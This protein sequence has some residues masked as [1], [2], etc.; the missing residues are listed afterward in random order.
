MLGVYVDSSKAFDLINY[1]ILLKRLE[2]CR[3]CQT[4]LK[5][6]ESY[7]LFSTQFVSI[8]QSNSSTSKTGTEV[9]EGSV[10]K[11]LL[12]IQFINFIEQCAPEVKFVS[13]A[14]CYF[15]LCSFIVRD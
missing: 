15:C 11:P 5:L 9:L 6:F 13:Y 2:H 7:L 4:G 1:T 8:N 3:V 14:D 10:L 12:F